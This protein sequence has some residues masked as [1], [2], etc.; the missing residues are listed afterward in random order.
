MSTQDFTNDQRK[1]MLEGIHEREGDWDKVNIDNEL[2]EIGIAA[3]LDEDGTKQLFKVL[4]D[5]D[6]I[7]TGRMLQAGDAVR[8]ERNSETIEY[9][10]LLIPV[11]Y[12]M[13]LTDRGKSYINV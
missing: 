3:G 8:F 7:D 13:K 4:I 6:Y 10:G 11:S 1:T 2:G 9:G 12:N 5:E